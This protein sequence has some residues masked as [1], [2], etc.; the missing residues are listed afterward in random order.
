MG[1]NA[2]KTTNRVR[3]ASLRYRIGERMSTPLTKSTTGRASRAA[4]ARLTAL[5]ATMAL[6]GAV[7]AQVP[8]DT[9]YPITTQQRSVAD[10]VAQAGVPL[11]E[12]APNAPD[13]YTVKSGDT[14]WDISKIYLT[15]PWRW[16]ELWGMNKQQVRN[17]HLIYPGQVLQLVRSG[18]R[19]MLRVAGGD[20]GVDRLSPQVRDVG[21]SGRAI[22]S[23]P[24]KAIEPFLS[25]PAIISPDELAKY[26]RIVATPENR[27]YIGNGDIAYARGLNDDAVAKYN[28]FR[29]ARPLYDPDDVERRNPIAYEAEYLGVAQLKQAGEVSTVTIEES[30]LEIGVG[31]RLIP[32]V[33]Q[34]IIAFVPRRPEKDVNGRVVSVYGGVSEAGTFNIITLNRG[35]RD[36]VEIGNVFALLEN[37]KTILDQT[38]ANREFVKLPDERIGEVFVFRTFE[39]ISYGLVMRVQKPVAVGDRFSPPDATR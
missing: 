27:V 36:G 21:P 39:N 29:P 17:P 30:K 12:L 38:A 22:A 9:R 26:P 2:Q 4:P 25:R 8:A 35:T 24:F 16:P 7:S 32:I 34:P 13:T 28:V 33:A 23:I 19:A 3:H 15:S 5:A 14:L 6:A 1:T 31:D 37:G 11:S 20:P 10:Q 18:D